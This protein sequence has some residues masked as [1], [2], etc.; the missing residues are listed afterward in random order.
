MKEIKIVLRRD[1][2]DPVVQALAE[3]DVPRFHVSHV[4]VLGAGI[5]PS[6]ARLSLEEGT[7]FTEK[8]KIEV[9]CR[10]RDVDRIIDLVR[11]HAATGMRG[12]GVVAVTDVTRLV[13]VRSGE[14][15]LLAVV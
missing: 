5:D 7:R 8:A 6:D 15:G 10:E 14:E 12:D 9:F 4:H 1:R 11:E 3:A 13:S 2:V